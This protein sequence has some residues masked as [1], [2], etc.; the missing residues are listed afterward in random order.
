MFQFF[1]RTGHGI[2]VTANFFFFGGG[3]GQNENSVT[4]SILWNGK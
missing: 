2:N 4:V 3:E 1:V